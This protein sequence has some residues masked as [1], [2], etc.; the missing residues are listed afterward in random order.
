MKSLHGAD[1]FFEANSRLDGQD[2]RH[3]LWDYEIHHSVDKIPPFLHF[4]S[5]INLVHTLSPHSVS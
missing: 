1:S 3:Y 5:Q 2:I 4:L